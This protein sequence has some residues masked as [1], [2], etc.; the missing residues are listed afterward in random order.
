MTRNKLIKN[1]I[2]VN[3]IKIKDVNFV[4]KDNGVKKVIVNV[5]PFKN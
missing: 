1:L 3:D 5:E 4:V 2:G